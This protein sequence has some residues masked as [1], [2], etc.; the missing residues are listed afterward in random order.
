[1]ENLC[2]PRCSDR[3]KLCAAIYYTPLCQIH[4]HKEGIISQLETLEGILNNKKYGL[5]SEQYG[6]PSLIRERFEASLVESSVPI[7]KNR[8]TL[9]KKPNKKVLLVRLNE[10]RNILRDMFM[11]TGT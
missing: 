11:Q 2:D 1:M 4:S 6:L 5:L 8:T 7:A 9:E 10:R 3:Y